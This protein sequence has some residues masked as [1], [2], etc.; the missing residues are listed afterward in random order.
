MCPSLPPQQP[1]GCWRTQ[2]R[3]DLL[4]KCAVLYVQSRVCAMD[5]PGGG[6]GAGGES[7]AGAHSGWE[8][9]QSSNERL[10]VSHECLARELHM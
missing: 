2:E 4:L 8:R 6:E 3:V 1:R 5:V 9:C 10:R 7:E